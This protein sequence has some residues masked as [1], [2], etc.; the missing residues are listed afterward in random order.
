MAQL[1]ETAIAKLK[2]EHGDVRVITFPDGSEFVFRR[3]KRSEYDLWQD[4][5]DKEISRSAAARQLAQACLVT[6][7][8]GELLAAL[9]QW[10]GGLLCADGILDTIVTMAGGLGGVVAVK[11]A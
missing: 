4:S 5:K 9:E 3:P 10:A 2:S 8:Y 6:P 7:G 11:K 1:D